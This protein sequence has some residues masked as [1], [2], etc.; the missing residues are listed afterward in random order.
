MQRNQTL[1]FW[2]TCMFYFSLKIILLGG[3]GYVSIDAIWLYQKA[4]KKN[5]QFHL[6]QVYYVLC[7]KE[8]RHIH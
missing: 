7:N 2:A 8:I 1:Q 5:C 6:D 3:V 4:K